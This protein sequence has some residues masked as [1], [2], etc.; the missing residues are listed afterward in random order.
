MALG[1]LHSG[2]V[3]KSDENAPL[4]ARSAELEEAALN[5]LREAD[6]AHG[7]VEMFNNPL[8]DQAASKF[9]RN[10][11]NSLS[12]YSGGDDRNVSEHVAQLED[13]RAEQEK[14]QDMAKKVVKKAVSK[15]RAVSK[16][17]STSPGP[18]TPADQGQKQVKEVLAKGIAKMAKKK[19]VSPAKLEQLKTEMSQI[20]KDFGLQLAKVYNKGALTAGV[21]GCRKL[22]DENRDSPE[23]S[24]VFLKALSN[25]NL[26]QIAKSA[27][28]GSFQSLQQHARLF[29]YLALQFKTNLKDSRD[30]PP[31]RTKTVRKMIQTIIDLF[32]NESNERIR[33]ACA[34]SIRE[35]Y[36]NAFV[37]GKY[38]KEGKPAKELIFGPIFDELRESG[39]RVMRQ[40]AGAVLKK[41]NRDFKYK[42]DVVDV[43]HCLT[44]TQLGMTAKIYDAE[45]LSA[46]S[47]LI[48]ECGPTVVL[49][50]HLLKTIPYILASLKY[51][52]GGTNA[53]GKVQ[54]D[55]NINSSIELLETLANQLK[56]MDYGPDIGKQ[57]EQEVAE[58]MASLKM[59]KSAVSLPIQRA[60]AKALRL[61]R[62]LA[63]SGPRSAVVSSAGQRASSAQPPKS[64]TNAPLTQP[65]KMKSKFAALSA[66]RPKSAGPKKP[67]AGAQMSKLSDKRNLIK[68]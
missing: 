7:Q 46:L 4:A 3:E 37:D 21:E 14:I 58:A 19:S 1:S 53:S 66:L 39:G 61:W 6:L 38:G 30:Q 43:A 31:S 13:A 20:E 50:K 5:G 35:I 55:N 44:I 12:A 11:Q 51:N 9:K 34:D 17:K 45:F 40:T 56:A 24:G 59:E 42:Q 8:S 32:F 27:S 49:G 57:F 15:K 2:R 18:A 22:I 26:L 10:A 47:D 63:T 67:R 29:G 25:K 33:E 48:E 28:A 65:Q 36:E 41:L 52:I 62:E 68:Q 64:S 54:R 60:G 16:S 23:V